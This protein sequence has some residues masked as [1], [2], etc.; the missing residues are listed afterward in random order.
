M[1]VVIVLM[2]GM[3]RIQNGHI[4]IKEITETSSNTDLLI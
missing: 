1:I 4:E 2:T 3:L